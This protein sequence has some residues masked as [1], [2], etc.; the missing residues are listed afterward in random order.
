MGDD[1]VAFLEAGENLLSAR[2]QV[3]TDPAVKGQIEG[4]LSEVRRNRRTEDPA[5]AETTP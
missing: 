4:S 2:L 5:P 1:P 3:E